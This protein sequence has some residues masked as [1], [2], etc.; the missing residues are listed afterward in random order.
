[1]KIQERHARHYLAYAYEHPDDWD[2][3]DPEW[4]QI[5]H[6]WEWMCQKGNEQII[7]DYIMAFSSYQ[8]RRGFLA[9]L[10]NWAEHGLR[11]I[12]SFPVTKH[13]TTQTTLLRSKTEASLL[14]SISSA[15]QSLG[16]MSEALDSYHQALAI[17][18][19]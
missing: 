16:K 18:K 8:K 11:A 12:R 17:F 3:F 1:M 4:G 9:D 19:K 5:Q 13:E 7:L 10:L 6:A 15:L 14:H 2:R